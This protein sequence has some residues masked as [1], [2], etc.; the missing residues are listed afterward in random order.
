[1]YKEN[2]QF[3]I[4]ICFKVVHDLDTVMEEDWRSAADGEVDVSYTRKQLG[5]YDEAALENGL[6]LADQ[7]RL[8][9]RDVEVTALTIG[10]EAQDEIFKNLYAV[11]CDRVVFWKCEKDLR[12]HPEGTARRI[13]SFVK[14]EGG[15]DL[16]LMGQ[17]ASVGDSGR[18]PWAAAEYLGLPAVSQVRE[19]CLRDGAVLA[20]SEAEGW[21]R[22]FLCGG[23]AVCALGNAKYPYLRVATLREKLVSG[24]KQVLVRCDA[25]GAGNA[26]TWQGG[27]KAE[28]EGQ[29]EP[30]ES[31]ETEG[32]TE[33]AASAEPEGQTELAA[34]AEPEGQAEQAVS[35][36]QAAP[37]GFRRRTEERTCAVVEGQNTRARAERLYEILKEAGIL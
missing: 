16:I 21:E 5:C 30:A 32:Q 20:V 11:K 34:S 31:A 27:G 25:D 36:E 17:Q 13:A 14:A 3:R 4:L 7:M 6:R 12:F 1:M 22:S 2:Q 26:G 28:L 15:F 35:A 19:L 33:L 18:V 9:G 29:T 23:A 37:V 10:Q 8:S 24:K